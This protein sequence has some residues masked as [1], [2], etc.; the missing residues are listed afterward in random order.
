MADG[1]SVVYI[2][3]RLA[4]VRELADPVTVLRDGKVRGTAEVAA[5]TDGELLA[6]IVGRQLDSTFPDKLGARCRRHR[7]TSCCDGLTGT[8]FTD[9][10]LTATPGQIIGVAGVVGNGQSDLMRALA[11]LESFSGTVQV[12]GRATS[13]Q[14]PAAP[15]GVPARR[16]AARRA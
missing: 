1:T 13:G 5:I 10:S 6:M 15:R 12:G 4:E 7:R 3:H 11:G 8:G 16:P 9:V 2:T 14:G